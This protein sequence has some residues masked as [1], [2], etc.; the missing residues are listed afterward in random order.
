MKRLNGTN[1]K[2]LVFPT[3]PAFPAFQMSRRLVSLL[4]VCGHV[5]LIGCQ[6]AI[7][8]RARVKE[9]KPFALPVK[10]SA[11]LDKSSDL[12]FLHVLGDSGAA[13]FSATSLGVTIPALSLAAVDLSKVTDKKV[14][15]TVIKS[16][17]NYEA[18]DG[19]KKKITCKDVPLSITAAAVTISCSLTGDDSDQAQNEMI[20]S[21]P[22]K[23]PDSIVGIER[24][25]WIAMATACVKNGDKVFGRLNDKSLVGCY[26][27]KSAAQWA[28]SYYQEYAVSSPQTATSAFE[29]DCGSTGGVKLVDTLASKCSALKGTDQNKEG[30]YV[31]SNIKDVLIDYKQF[32]TVAEPLKAFE[33]T[34][35]LS[36]SG[37]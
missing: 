16:K 6:Q 14:E 28:F 36:C 30:C 3:F 15:L 21:L 11:P 8:Q 2:F 31:C 24:E 26:C 34:V 20:N 4:L 1:S 10:L 19:A 27:A 29:Y 13:V 32:F 22:F 17:L 35:Q 25:S 12:S 33:Q 5:A 7:V 23:I 18:S 9:G 37:P